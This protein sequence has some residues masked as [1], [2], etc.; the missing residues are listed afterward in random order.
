M[1]SFVERLPGLLRELSEPVTSYTAQE[2][3]CRIHSEGWD[4]CVAT[5]KNELDGDDSNVKCLVLDIIC[6]QCEQMGQEHAEPFHGIIERLLTDKHPRSRMAAILAVRHLLIMT[7]SAKNAL[8]RIA[9]DDEPHISCEAIVTL[10]ELDPKV[11]SEI[12]G[13]LRASPSWRTAGIGEVCHD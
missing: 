8:R 6:E 9:C 7:T 4:A 13:L 11:A 5:L 2:L 1:V 10:L 12:S 3:W